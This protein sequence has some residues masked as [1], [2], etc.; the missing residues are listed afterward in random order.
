MLSSPDGIWVVTASGG[1]LLRLDEG[2]SRMQAPGT[3][4]DG[5]PTALATAF[6]SIWIASADSGGVS[7]VSPHTR[8]VT[9]R[10]RVGDSPS[11]L[12]PD[13]HGLWVV[14]REDD[15]LVRINPTTNRLVGRPIHIGDEPTAVGSGSG[16]VWVTNSGDDTVSRIDPRSRRV[17]ATIDVGDHPTGLTVSQGAVWVANFEDDNVQRIDTTANRVV[18]TIPVADG[19]NYPRMAKTVWVPNSRDGT[20][21]R[22]DPR[23]NRVLGRSVRVAQT[24]D[25]IST[26]I[27]NLWVTS[28]A[29]QTLTRL[30]G[31]D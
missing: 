9:E 19:P 11:W 25:R 24:A 4:I 1:T 13:A 16:S 30:E 18:A 2:L 26:G 5:R 8:L 22:I 12:S 6:R 14:N 29:D 28:Y 31:A 27:Q 10:I 7:R 23:T 21:S 3:P 15:T 17:V 20:L